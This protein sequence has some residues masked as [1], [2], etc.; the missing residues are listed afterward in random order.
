M[1]IQ[2]SLNDYRENK[3]FSLL[4]QNKNPK[5]ELDSKIQAQEAKDAQNI[6][7]KRGDNFGRFKSF[8]GNQIEEYK[9]FWDTQVKALNA[10]KSKDPSCV[11][12]YAF[13]N[14][15]GDK[16]SP[17]YLICLIGQSIENQPILS[18]IKTHLEEGED[19]PIFSTKD[20]M[21]IKEFSRF[22]NELKSEMKK[23]KDHYISTVEN[24]R[25]EEEEKKRRE[26]LDKFLKESKRT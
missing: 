16:Y 17:N 24:K 14:D 11:Q 6:I 13:F 25:R 18:V 12:V 4:E 21:A 7:K 19:N 8:A 20:K 9:K 10:V 2:E 23:I 26:K 1:N 22:Y 5:R 3:F 15:S